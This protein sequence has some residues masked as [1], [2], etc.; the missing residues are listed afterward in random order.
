MKALLDIIP[1]LTVLPYALLYYFILLSASLLA[2][3]ALRRTVGAPYQP[4]RAL[5]AALFVLFIAQTLLLTLSLLIFQGFSSLSRFFPLIF[6]ALTLI[7]LIWLCAGLLYDRLNSRAARLPVF[8]SGF[9]LLAGMLC[10]LAWSARPAEE[11]FAG[12]VFSLAW[13]GAALLVLL[14]GLLLALRGRRAHKLE[15]VLILLIAALG[16]LANILYPTESTLPSG[17]MLS[18]LLYYPLLISAAW[19]SRR[20]EQPRPA[21]ASSPQM[22]AAFLDLGLVERV[23]EI[24][25]ALTHALSLFLM[26]DLVGIMEKDAQA[27]AFNVSSMYDLISESYLPTFQLPFKQVPKLRRHFEDLIPLTANADEQ[28]SSEK[29]AIMRASAYNAAGSL[30]LYPLG[31]AGQPA[32]FALLCVNPYTK[33]IW[34]E[35]DLQILG[36]LSGKIYQVLDRAALVEA[37]SALKDQSRYLSNQLE[38]EKSD[39]AAALSSSRA[40]INALRAQRSEEESARAVELRV[41]QE[42]QKYLETQLD[43]LSERLRTQTEALG[44]L[45]S[46]RQQKSA[47]ALALEENQQRAGELQR[48]L[49]QAGLAQNDLKVQPEAPREETPELASAQ[50]E[51]L[52]EESD[53][54]NQPTGTREALQA[55]LDET[56]ASFYSRRVALRTAIEDIP[57]MPKPELARLQKILENL[58]INAFAAAPPESEVLVQVRTVSADGESPALE[59]LSTH[60]GEGIA[61]EEQKRLAEL[62]ELLEAPSPAGLGD[63]AVLREAARLLR[64]CGGHWWLKSEPG[65]LTTWRALIPMNSRPDPNAPARN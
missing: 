42:R 61:P 23:S 25:A 43:L 30:L 56:A 35:S 46:L 34:T 26:G 60:A 37:G 64:E 65:S 9:T 63:F 52:A 27:N 32:R 41:C 4:A 11:A 49:E 20:R 18:Q 16:Y 29:Q 54:A 44:E 33:R 45:E 57:D 55:A 51:A 28:L 31:S 10:V 58:A 62:L 12:S 53:R 6:H 8:L 24:R 14:V 36:E 13:S 19:Q 22:A 59:I 40:E 1:L 21:G 48:R 3:L 39:L 47:L 17:V 50:P 7:T 2:A 15:R 5:R 38:R